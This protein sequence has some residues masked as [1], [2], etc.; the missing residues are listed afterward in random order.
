MSL[1]SRLSSVVRNVFA[2]EHVE[3]ALDAELSAYLDELAAEKVRAGRTVE[4]ARREARLEL[5]GAEQVKEQVRT[6]R[7]GALVE[8]LAQDV[9]F[10]FRQLRRSPGFATVVVLTLGSPQSC[11][12]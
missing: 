1:P 10:G 9:R 8:Q 5:G 7:A 11:A 3:H 2:G 12:M 4:E 6:A